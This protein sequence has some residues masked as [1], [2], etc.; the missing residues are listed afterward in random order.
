MK[1][2][3][4]QYFLWQRTACW[5]I[6]L[7]PFPNHIL[8]KLLRNLN[9]F[10]ENSK[11][12]KTHNLQ[13]ILFKI[14]TKEF[15]KMPD[16]KST[17]PNRR[18]IH[19]QCLIEFF[20]KEWKSQLS[21]YPK[22][23]TCTLTALCISHMGKWTCC[24]KLVYLKSSPRWFPEGIPDGTNCSLILNFVNTKESTSVFQYIHNS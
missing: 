4:I 23:T 10:S 11:L 8:P 21:L 22:Y 2:L 24:F 19:K 20:M 12:K 17:P 14:L 3:S 13:Q 9:N 16:H 5:L 6:L 7:G 1:P 15:P 18:L